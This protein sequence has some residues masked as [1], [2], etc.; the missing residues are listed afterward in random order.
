[1]DSKIGKVK[2][3]TDLI[4]NNF[5]Y[6]ASMKFRLKR[7]IGTIINCKNNLIGKD[8]D[9]YEKFLEDDKESHIK[10]ENSYNIAEIT[11]LEYAIKAKF[12]KFHK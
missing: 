11:D 10:F 5:L 6:N 12:I 2:E 1:M 8:V 9:G 3:D 4:S 7:E